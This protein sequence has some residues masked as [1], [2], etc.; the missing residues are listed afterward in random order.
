MKFPWLRKPLGSGTS[1]NLKELCRETDEARSPSPAPR[2]FV[3]WY[4]ALAT[5]G[6]SYHEECALNVVSSAFSELLSRV[7]RAECRKR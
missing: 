3:F 1:G 5:R 2:L 4:V 7:S 6:L